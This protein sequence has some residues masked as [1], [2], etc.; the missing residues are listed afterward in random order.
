MCK[1]CLVIV[2]IGA[3]LISFPLHAAAI[4]TPIK[5]TCDGSFRGLGARQD[6]PLR[7]IFLEISKS[8]VKILGVPVFSGGNTYKINIYDEQSVIFRSNSK[9]ISGHINRS[10]GELSIFEFVDGSSVIPNSFDAIC[11]PYRPIF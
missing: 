3:A 6:I 2:F 7:G 9:N 10:N 4:F 1:L 11:T 8:Y 5:L